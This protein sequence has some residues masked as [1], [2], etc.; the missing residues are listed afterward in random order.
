[1]KTPTWKKLALLL[2]LGVTA[3]AW[4]VAPPPAGLTVSTTAP[5]PKVA[6]FDRAAVAA[7]WRAHYEPGL[8][9][10][11]SKL[12]WTGN[13]DTCAAG[14]INPA[15]RTEVLR[16]INW[17]RALIGA[18]SDAVLL[19]ERD[20]KNQAGALVTAANWRL[21]HIIDP[22]FKCYTAAAEESTLR[23]NLGMNG[24]VGI[25]TING[26]MIDAGGWNITAG[27]RATLLEGEWFGY[28]AVL[29]ADPQYEGLTWLVDN[30][31][32]GGNGWADPVT[33]LHQLRE[34]RYYAFPPAGFVPENA[35]ASNEADLSLHWSFMMPEADVTQ[36]VVTMNDGINTWTP[37][38]VWKTPLNDG[39]EAKGWYMV[40][41]GPSVGRQP[42]QNDL[43]LPL[44]PL[45]PAND[46]KWTVT[47]SGIVHEGVA[48]SITYP[49]YSFNPRDTSVN[50]VRGAGQTVV[51]YWHAGL[52][53]YF[54]TADANEQAFVDSG[55][56]GTWV[57]TGATFK[58][59][60]TN[61]VCRFYGNR[62]K[63][64]NGPNSHFYTADYAECDWVK[65]D[66]GWWL[67]SFEAF[68]VTPATGGTCPGGTVPIYRAYNDGFARGVDSN[69]RITPDRAAYEAT[70]ARG[71]KG[72]G[73]VMCGGAA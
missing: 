52:D 68:W 72:E 38:I 31:Y 7:H 2:A 56:A 62:S 21:E 13:L 28:G 44:L 57:R 70:V 23:S 14:N 30:V 17:F 43:P 22:T 50:P 55:G 53:H 34:K 59:G 42:Y 41:T 16:R 3:P 63:V 47:I 66:E 37:K 27:H 39:T 25:D 12:A 73:V 65:Q 35:V 5:V 64:R 54:I 11:A 15:F 9:W 61:P 19:G 1:M 46:R 67:E 32:R 26:Y 8:G 45:G 10:N 48:R 20:T 33:S 51:E 71:W 24:K 4:A 36:A 58:S 40:W 49:V 60:G 29:R 18:P 6:M 69:H